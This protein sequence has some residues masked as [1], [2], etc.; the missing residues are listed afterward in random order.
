MALPH[1]HPFSLSCL[2]VALMTTTT[3]SQAAQMPST[4]V[5]DLSTAHPPVSVVQLP[6]TDTTITNSDSQNMSYDT[7]ITQSS[8]EY[9]NNVNT[10]VANSNVI[11]KTLPADAVDLFAQCASLQVDAARLACYDKV[12]NAGT[13]AIPSTKKPLNITKTVQA[14]WQTLSP[15]LVLASDDEDTA[16]DNERLSTTDTNVNTLTSTHTQTVS[17][18]DALVSAPTM[19]DSEAQILAKVG[20]TPSDIGRYTPLSLSYDLD[21]NSELGLWSARPYNPMYIL[22]VF[23][24]FNPNRSPGT[25]TQETVYYDEDQQRNLE[26]KAQLSFKT[27][28]MEDLFDTNADLWFGYTQQMHWQVYNENNSRPFRATDYEPEFFLT[29]PVTA[30]LPFNGRLRML[31]AG[32]IHHSNGQSD[33]LSRSWNRLYLMGGMEWGNLSVIPRV[34]THVKA[35]DSNKPSDNPDIT[36]YYGYGDLKV[37]YDF[38]QGHSLG[39]TGRYNFAKQKGALQLDYIHPLTDEI[40]GFVQ[41]FHGYGESIIDYNK[42]TTAVGL[43]VSLNGWKGL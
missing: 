3:T 10:V 40:Q 5:D 8:G 21:K 18:T 37:L 24:G 23:Y 19:T 17:A 34:W 2:T 32:A 39:A 11:I 22:P 16:H 33:P 38:G 25:P 31:G 35:S 7:A 26:L 6:P 12:A 43:G 27:K 20:V 1:F 13:V 15:Q 9:D 28:V 14:S 36:D 42:S 4:T 29:Q 41:I 30:N